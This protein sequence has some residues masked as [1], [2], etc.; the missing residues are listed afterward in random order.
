MAGLG[1]TYNK[2]R[3]V[4]SS[5]NAVSANSKLESKVVFAAACK[6]TYS[7]A[8]HNDLPRDQRAIDRG[9]PNR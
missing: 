4:S 6:L 5:R 8:N 1:M 2:I 9:I 3:R 7:A